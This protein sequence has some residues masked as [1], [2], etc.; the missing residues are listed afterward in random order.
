[1][2]IG[3]FFLVL[4]VAIAVGLYVG[5]PFFQRGRRRIGY[6]AHE[7]SALMAERD[8]IVNALQEL[9]FDFNL[10]KIPAE[11]Y[12]LQRAELLKK[13]AEILRQLDSLLP[14]PIIGSPAGVLREG[15]GGEGAADRIESAVAARRADLA[16]ARAAVRED[17]DIEALIAARRKARKEKSG[18]F[19]PRC[20]KPVLASDRFCPHCGKSIA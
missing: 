16:S 2:E 10:D 1:M 5:Q 19:C 17:D 7:I 11:D 13:G 9:D 8:R 6:E 4:A 18:G 12:P 15:A 14:S 3:A 20:G